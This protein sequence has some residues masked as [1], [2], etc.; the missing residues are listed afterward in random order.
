MYFGTFPLYNDLRI[1][2]FCAS[3]NF[4]CTNPTCDTK[5]ECMSELTNDYEGEPID[6]IAYTTDNKPENNNEPK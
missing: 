4:I 3:T 2:Y 5:F 1:V 6:D